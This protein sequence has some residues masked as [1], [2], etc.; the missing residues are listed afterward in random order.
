MT[1][2]PYR[3][4][5]FTDTEKD[6]WEIISTDDL[7]QVVS[8]LQYIKENSPTIQHRGLG[9]NNTRQEERVQIVCGKVEIPANKKSDNVAK[10]V[11]F[12]AET[13]LAGSHVHI[14]L[15]IEGAHWTDYHKLHAVA[16]GLNGA[17][18]PSY[19]GFRVFVNNHALDP[20]ND[21]MIR[22]IRVHWIAIGMA[23][24]VWYKPEI[25]SVDFS[26]IRNTSSGTSR[27]I[28]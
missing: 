3:K 9:T 27:V 23:S 15:G 24:N 14:A 25:P 18:Y 16:Q 26:N 19:K 8:N 1:A 2:T 5:D 13:F 20:R 22:M 12:P 6:A 28:Q 17:G 4:V 11:K 21:K 10:N 7:N